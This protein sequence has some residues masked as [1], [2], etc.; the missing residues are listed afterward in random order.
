[1][2]KIKDSVHINI[3]LGISIPIAIACLGL[4]IIATLKTNDPDL[5]MFGVD[6]LIIL[7]M[8]IIT[9]IVVYF[10]KSIDK[11]SSNSKTI[12]TK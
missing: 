7:G 4:V 10:D 2:K 3:A 9:S 8:G 6:A 11:N 12:K 1:M 5:K